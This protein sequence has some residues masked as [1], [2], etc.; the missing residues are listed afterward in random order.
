MPAA[1][2][3]TSGASSNASSHPLAYSGVEST[4]QQPAPSPVPSTSDHG[5][6]LPGSGDQDRAV[7]GPRPYTPLQCRRFANYLVCRLRR[8]GMPLRDEHAPIRARLYRSSHVEGGG[9][10]R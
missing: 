4:S 9:P 5:I 7:F 2:A 8:I 1:N 10:I 6:Q 3:A